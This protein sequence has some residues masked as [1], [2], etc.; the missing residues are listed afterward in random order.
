MVK[1]FY[2]VV[3]T[4][5]SQQHMKQIHKYISR[6][7]LKNAEKVILDITVAVMK[8]V[9][10]PECYRSDKYKKNND[11]SFRAFEKH[12]YRVVYR[13]SKNII[14]VLR[15]RHTSREPKFY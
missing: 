12:Q 3:W 1:T 13:F 15:V 2:E 7:S 5:R 14:R 4:T 9:T 11:G 8:A 6:D 10:N